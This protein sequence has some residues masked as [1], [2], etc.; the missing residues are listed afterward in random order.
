MNDSALDKK[1]GDYTQFSPKND[2]SKMKINL[3][4]PIIFAITPVHGL[5]YRIINSSILQLI[6]CPKMFIM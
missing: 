6:I 4:L 2:C 3:I 5:N 1:Q